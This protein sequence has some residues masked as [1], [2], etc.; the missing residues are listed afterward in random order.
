M[1]GNWVAIDAGERVMLALALYTRLGGK[2]GFPVPE[3]LSLCTDEDVARATR[4]GLAMA[5]G[6]RLSGGMAEGLE[7][8]RLE[9]TGD[10]L[11]LMLKPSLASLAAKSIESRLKALAND[12]GV[13][14]EVVL[15]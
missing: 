12:R 7:G 6:Q 2:G 8:N 13:K 14:A 1:H 15:A 10:R 5:L 4:W 3:V 9:R 11:R